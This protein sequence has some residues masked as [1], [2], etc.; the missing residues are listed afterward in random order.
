MKMIHMDVQISSTFFLL[1]NR[2]G[3][4]SIS[5]EVRLSLMNFARHD[6]A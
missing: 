3:V 2:S 4:V 1:V 5:E 6:L